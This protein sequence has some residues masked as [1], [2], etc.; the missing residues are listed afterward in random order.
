MELLAKLFGSL[1][2]VKVL[3]LFI[4]NA[5]TNFTLSEMSG[6]LKLSSSSLRRELNVLEA[7]RFLTTK[8]AYRFNA[9]GTRKIK[10]KVW[11][12]NQAYPFNNELREILNFEITE[13]RSDLV[14][15]F[16]NCGKLKLVI[17]SGF[18]L[19]DP[20]G[21]VDLTVVGDRLNKT[22]IERTIHKIESEV[23]KEL[24]F[25][26]LETSD[27]Q[28]RLFSGDKFIRDIFDF[29]YEYALNKMPV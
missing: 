20:D 27:Y 13:G 17:L 24:N 18:F 10:V 8:M 28:Y 21:R 7:A 19:N 6:R 4:F 23:G 16:K 5:E 11:Q 2:K 14:K 22:A 9:R 12:L 26:I 29:P 3:R 25:A 15:R 1:N